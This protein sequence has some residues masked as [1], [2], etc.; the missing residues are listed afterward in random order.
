MGKVTGAGFD[1][2]F[3]DTTSTTPWG[4]YILLIV[5]AVG[6]LFAVGASIGRRADE[7]TE[8]IPPPDMQDEPTA[9]LMK[10]G[11]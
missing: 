2:R 8:E 1:D 6:I 4:L 7:H 10:T 5:L 9:Q 3:A 11:V